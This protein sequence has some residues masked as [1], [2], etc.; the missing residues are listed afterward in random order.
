MTDETIVWLP[1]RQQCKDV[2]SLDAR[3]G[4]ASRRS[5]VV[6]TTDYVVATTLTG[7]GRMWSPYDKD[8]ARQQQL[9]KE[10][11]TQGRERWDRITRG[12][13]ETIYKYIQQSQ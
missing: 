8:P 11:T 4:S 12:R 9:V 13:A 5:I 2:S 10:L 3:I 1:S 6:C 7:G